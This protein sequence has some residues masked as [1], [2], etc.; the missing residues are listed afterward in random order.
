MGQGKDLLREEAEELRSRLLP[1]RGDL[2]KYGWRIPEIF[3]TEVVGATGAE[4]FSYEELIGQGDAEHLLA[5]PTQP[6]F[7]KWFVIRK[8]LE[9]LALYPK[10]SIARQAVAGQ[11]LSVLPHGLD[12]KPANL[13]LEPDRNELYFVDLFGPKEIDHRTGRWRTYSPK[14]DTLPEENLMAVCAT[15]EGAILRFYRLAERLWAETAGIKSSA[16]REEFLTMLRTTGLP[17][18]ETTFIAHE[19]KNDFPWLNKLYSEQRI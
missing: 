7:R 14:L 2:A 5:H 8:T 12:L 4:I 1:Y 19:L 17:G 18:Q 13:V 15:R 11:E 3:H 9:T 16:L 6:H 10:E